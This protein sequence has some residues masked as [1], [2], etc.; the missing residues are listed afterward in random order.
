VR[1]AWRATPLEE[2]EGPLPCDGDTIHGR[3]EGFG[4]YTL[5]ADLGTGWC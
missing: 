3:V 1:G 2:K 5:Y 4:I